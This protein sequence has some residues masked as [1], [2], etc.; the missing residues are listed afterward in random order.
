MLVMRRGKL[1]IQITSRS[2]REQEALAEAIVADPTAAKF[3]KKH[4]HPAL[5]EVKPKPS[6]KGIH[7]AQK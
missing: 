5:N 4:N 2:L 6:R 7:R 3:N 1:N